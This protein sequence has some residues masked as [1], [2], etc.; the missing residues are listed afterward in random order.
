MVLIESNYSVLK[1]GS[2]APSFELPGVDGKTYSI[3]GYPGS[4]AYLVVFM[5]NHCPYVKPKMKYLK[6]L[7]DKYKPKGLAM[8]GISSN[9]PAAVGEDDFENMKRVAKEQ[10]FLFPYLFDETQKI[11]KI[12]GAV[13]TPDPFLFD[14]D[15]KLVYHGRIDNAHKEMH[16]NAST[17][18]LEEAIA[19]V[20]AGKKNTLKE[21]P[22]F[23]CS[24][25]WKIN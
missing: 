17:N 5:C 11:A 12:Y 8:F 18:E 9:D 4:K 22:S 1:K 24:I 7:Y 16:E 13:C 25:K 23:G 3:D 21:E 15:K 2:L 19:Q 10:K 14:S 6:E 20:L